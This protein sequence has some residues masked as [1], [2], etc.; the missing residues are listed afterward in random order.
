MTAKEYLLQIRRLDRLINNLVRERNTL[1]MN[2]LG[3]HS[4][5]L[6]ADKVQTSGGGGTMADS[7]D[8]YVD[9]E[10]ELTVMLNK[11]RK[12]RWRIVK[13][14]NSL[15]DPRHVELLYLK[16]VEGK[17]LEDIACIMRKPNGEIY[18][19]EYIKR[20]HGWALE[21]FLKK[22]PNVTEMSP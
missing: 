11:Y 20:L 7:I 18:N 10:H 5:R 4:P 12:M 19:Y 3:N 8:K 22:Y 6:V 13:E 16:Y 9:I 21:S 17:C 1:R 15:P 14:I 2:A